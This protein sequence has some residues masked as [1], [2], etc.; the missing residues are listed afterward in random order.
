MA[1]LLK[2]ELRSSEFRWEG[3]TGHL[4][5]LDD[6]TQVC[7]TCYVVSDRTGEQVEFKFS[8]FT[9]SRLNEHYTSKCG[10]FEF[11]APKR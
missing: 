11:Y 4:L 10:K 9:N 3:N 2:H 7:A 6:D 1:Y 5:E 8:R